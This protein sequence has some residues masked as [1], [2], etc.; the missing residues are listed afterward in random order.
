MSLF[1]FIKGQFIDVIEFLDD[2]RD[3]LSWRFPDDDKEIKNGAQL[4][5]RESQVA[6]FVYLGEYGDCFGPGKHELQTDNIP[7]LTSLK[8]WKYGFNSPFKADVYF[9]TTRVFAGNKW[10]TASPVPMRDAD[11]GNVQ[12]RAYGIYDFRVV[13]PPKFLKEVVG[14]YHQFRLEDFTDVM[15][16]RM[17]SVFSGALQKAG[18][19]FFDLATRFG[20]IGDALLPVL[21][22][23]LKE[24]YGL[25]M[26]SFVIESVQLP[27]EV[28]AAIN[29]GGAIKA[30][31]DM[32][33]YLKYQ[34]GQG[35]EKGGSGG[36]GAAGA[37]MAMGMSIGQQIVQGMQ[38]PPPQPPPPSAQPPPAVGGVPDLLSPAQAAERVGVTEAD[39]MASLEAGDLKGRKIGSTWRISKKA[40][41]EF[42]GA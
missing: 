27:E 2:S 21:N 41:D 9:V 6:Q 36:L 3:T 26:T 38:Q 4:I 7:I 12:L 31:G 40:L 30:V 14:T 1:S 19:P 15:R 33:N 16:S 35:M 17:V 18:V 34:M 42:L 22:A 5:V 39:I 10:G 32:N 13:D 20:D 24:K 29:R 23:A 25:E 11:Y 37:E 8:S 28:Q